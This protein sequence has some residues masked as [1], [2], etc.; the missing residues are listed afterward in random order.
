MIIT[1]FL[2]LGSGA[3]A[4]VFV[5]VEKST[6]VDYAVKEI[7]RGK[8]RWGGRDALQDEIENLK[9]LVEAPN[10]VKFQDVFEKKDICYLVLEL[11]PGGELFAHIISKGTFTESEARDSCRCIL[12]AL[13]YMHDRRMVH[14]DLKP[15][16]LLLTVRSL[17]LLLLDIDCIFVFVS[18]FDKFCSATFWGIPV[19]A[20]SLLT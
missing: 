7:D 17:L 1:Q 2:Q 11:L 9:K 10:V 5:A 3:F 16:N 19:V 14:R 4:K 18:R 20:G 13:D 12:Q 15:E 6:R 8:M